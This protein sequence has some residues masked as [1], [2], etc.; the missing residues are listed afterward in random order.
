MCA[1]EGISLKGEKR[2]F[3]RSVQFV[4]L[5]KHSIGYIPQVENPKGIVV[6]GDY[7][8]IGKHFVEGKKND[9]FFNVHEF[10][11]QNKPIGESFRNRGKLV[12]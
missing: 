4:F 1:L 11:R 5:A 10:M 6:V 7:I 9:T 12:E 3:K 2:S 8:E